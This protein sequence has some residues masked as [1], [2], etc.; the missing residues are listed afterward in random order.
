TVRAV[1]QGSLPWWDPNLS[2]GEPLVE[3]PAQVFYPP[4]WPALLVPAGLFFACSVV[5]HHLFGGAGLYLFLRGQ[6]LSRLASAFGATLWMSSGPW[7]STV[8][9][10]NQF[11]GAAWMPW[12]LLAADRA[13]RDPRVS[14][15]VAWGASV[16][17]ALLAGSE[18]FLMPG[19]TSGFCSLR[20]AAPRQPPR[21]LLLLAATA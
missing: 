15:A 10:L 18:P 6:R 12:I 13:R 17:L 21:R 3:Y 14:A 20:P 5:A 9:M 19:V 11:S 16:A 7:L 1:G 4:F 8:N 2:F